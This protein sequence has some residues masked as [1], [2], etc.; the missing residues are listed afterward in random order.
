MPG[1]I[2]THIGHRAAVRW[3]ALSLA[4]TTLLFTAPPSSHAQDYGARLGV[5]RGGTVSFEPT[6]PGVMFGAMD[7]SIKKWYVPQELYTEFGWRQWEYSNYAR[8]HYERYVDTA[9]EGDFFY[10]FYGNYIGRGW[11]IYD[12]RQDQPQ[13]LGN[14]IFKDKRFTQWFSA[15]TVGG[16]SKGQYHY[17]ITV[18]NQLRTTLTPMTFSKP[19][20]NG[21]QIDFMADKYAATI[22]ASRVSDPISG[23][24][25]QGAETRTNATTMFGSRGTV[26]VGDFV[27]FGATAVA[28][29]H[30]NTTLDLFSG[31]LIA[32]SSTAG[33]SSSPLTAIAIILSDDSPEDGEGGAALFRHDVVIVSRNFETGRETRST[34]KEVVRSGA[35][36]PIVF[37]GFERTGFIAAD[38]AERIV[39]NY[40][41][42]DPAYIGPDPTSIVDVKFEY[43]LANDYKVQMW[44]DRQTG[45]RAMPS[46][47]LSA[48]TIDNSEPAL[49]TLRRAEGN[50]QDISNLSLV[51]FNYGLPT[52]NFVG[53]FTIE[54]SDI[55][56]FN[57]YGEW[58]RNTRYFQY[59]NAATFAS[60]DSHEISSESSDGWYVNVNRQNY[61]WF[62]Y[63]ESYSIDDAY[64]TTAFVTD[65]NGDINYDEAQ[66]HLYEFV[67]DNDDQDRY[68]DWVRFGTISDRLIFPGWDENND[69]ISDFNQNDNSTVTNLI[70]DYEEPFLRYEVDRPEFLFG[71]DLNNNDWIDRFEDD[72]VP[73]Y[74]YKPDREGRNIFGGLH[75]RPD[76]RLTIGRSQ[77][78]MISEDRS[79]N[80][81]YAML[82]AERSFPG[83]GRLRV[84]EM[85]KRVEDHIPDDR[86]EPTPF[87]DAPPIQPVVKDILPAQ[88]TW[89]NQ[90]FLGFDYTGIDNLRLRN[91]VKWQ[92]FH[93]AKSNL[94]TIDGLP[95][96]DA[97]SLLGLVNKVDYEY[98]LGTVTLQPRFKS[99]YLRQTAFVR[100]DDD[101]K[102]WA[103]AGYLL[104][105]LPAL[106]HTVL[107]AG[108]ELFWFRDLVAAED[109]MVDLGI[110]TD[111]GDFRSTTMALQLSNNSAYLGY[112]LT[113]QV[114]IR[115]G[116]TRTELVKERDNG[117]FKL[118]S[119][120]SNE[121]T[122]FITVY[123]GVDR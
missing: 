99:E 85:L 102:H 107:Q 81:N 67:D 80:V 33:Q 106:N 18:G 65:P 114:G 73:D 45:R 19:T 96:S 98:D 75:L 110:T 66:R 30:V 26:Q 21:V 117:T 34:L 6:G 119:E 112:S 68:P 77:E 59:P 95:I 52:A 5:Q 31:D 123:A 48:E 57:V 15:V 25:E 28:A 60:G 47:P 83:I 1:R 91:K 17:A 4:V 103:G 105:Q 104:A 53:G 12:W 9:L 50:V 62:V 58:D 79:S 35:E 40:D 90:S 69:F 11:L 54:G 46:P 121:T 16:D 70:P 72:D 116:R 43:V 120:S 44:S 42:N 8:D 29:R 97:S 36:W 37:G 71:I 94:R 7:P 89:V 87:V 76:V 78:E 56:G 74:P 49:I 14:S 2:V 108:V 39:L 13:Q 27:E 51:K 3:A 23:A 101:R 22:L 64:S 113:T 118:A 32:G 38:G 55:W 122:T 10:D 88:D 61:P 93:Q 100:G 92:L 115:L 82:T 41:F 84:F 109:E 63:G 24:T 20:F 111:T 86:R